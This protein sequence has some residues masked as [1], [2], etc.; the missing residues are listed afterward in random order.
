MNLKEL[1][2]SGEDVRECQIPIEWRESF[3]HFIMGQTCYLV[4]KSD[5]SGEKEF[6]FFSHD[7]R[8]WYHQNQASIE[9][10]IKLDDT[11]NSQK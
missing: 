6:V 10:D 1:Y 8:F 11:L 3:N 9:R 4:E 2:E 5:G 7:F